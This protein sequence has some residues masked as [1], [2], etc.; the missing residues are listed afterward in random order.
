MI[1]DIG[2]AGEAQMTISASDVQLKMDILQNAIDIVTKLSAE[3]K[4]ELMTS[5]WDKEY[6][7]EGGIM[8]YTNVIE[9]NVVSDDERAPK[10]SYEGYLEV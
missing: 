1:V 4:V 9:S 5:F 2:I 7:H 3:Q 10:D 6:D 8:F